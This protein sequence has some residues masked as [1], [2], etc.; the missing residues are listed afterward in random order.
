MDEV[1][2]EV[3]ACIERAI[4][5]NRRQ[6]WTVVGVLLALFATGLGMLVYGAVSQTWALLGSGGLIQVTIVFPVYR[7]I[8]LREENM[9]LQI[10]PQLMRLAATNEAKALAAQLVR[11][12]IEKV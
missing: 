4:A 9:R 3:T 8:R 2:R 11:R 5:K 7:L 12:L 10:L 6:E 1:V